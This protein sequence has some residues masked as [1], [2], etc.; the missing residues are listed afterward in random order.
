[1]E[2]FLFLSNNVSCWYLYFEHPACRNVRIHFLVSKAPSFEYFIV[3]KR[4]QRK[5]QQ[6]LYLPV[7]ISWDLAMEK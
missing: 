6:S 7:S 2:L 4:R 3:E 1:M 5:S